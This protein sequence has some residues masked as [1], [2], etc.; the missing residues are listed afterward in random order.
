M[1]IVDGAGLYSEPPASALNRF[2]E[3]LRVPSLS[4]GTYC[5]PR[6]GADDQR[7]HTEDEIYV[8]TR[9]RATVR[10]ERRSAVVG[11][12]DVIYVPAGEAHTFD[13]LEDLALLVLFAPPYTAPADPACG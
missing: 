5:I 6:R 11:P 2:T 3:H 9:G 12:G 8:V 13:V 7:P 10:T 1:D 4:V